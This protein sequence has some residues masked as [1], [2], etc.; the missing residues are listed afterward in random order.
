[1]KRQGTPLSKL[2][3]IFVLLSIL[4]TAGLASFAQT[5][6]LGSGTA[7]NGTTTISPVN[8]YYRS[9]HMQI[10]YTATEILAAGITAG[11]ALNSI[12]WYVTATPTYSLP[13]VHD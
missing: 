11:S 10:I 1:M 7:T 12:A 3:R 9:G 2:F 8:I 4:T 6:Q 5:I 13:P